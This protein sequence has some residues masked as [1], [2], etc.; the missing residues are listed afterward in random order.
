M[1]MEGEQRGHM[2]RPARERSR[3]KQRDIRVGLTASQITLSG[4]TPE[5][6]RVLV[7]NDHH[8][9]AYCCTGVAAVLHAPSTLE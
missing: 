2:T 7:I 3:T 6:C 8:G 4:F 5:V 9:A 1:R